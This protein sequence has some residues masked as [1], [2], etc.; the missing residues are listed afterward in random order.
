MYRKLSLGLFAAHLCIAW[1]YPL[2]ASSIVADKTFPIRNEQTRLVV[3]DAHGTPVRGASV[4]VTY[5]P[6]SSVEKSYTLG[7]S[8]AA[9]AVMWTPSDAGIATVT[10]TWPGP[11]QSQL[12]VSTTVSVRFHRAPWDGIIIMVIA[13]L[14]LAVGSVI[15]IFKLLR[16]SECT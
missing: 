5:R 12:S 2:L 1:S 8:D 11:D 15:R 3:S 10:G 13:G 16:S 14:V 9:G 6:G 4:T 7:E